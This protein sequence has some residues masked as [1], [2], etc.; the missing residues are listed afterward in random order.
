MNDAAHRKGTPLLVPP[1]SSMLFKTFSAAVFGMDA[2]LVEVEVDIG[3]SYQGNS[4]V[5]DLPA[6][7]V[8]ESRKRIKS[9]FRNCGFDFSL[10]AGGDSQ[11]SSR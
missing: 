4:K 10:Q 9:A 11:A 8:K 6:I 7:A 1:A 2:Y 3:P 5:V